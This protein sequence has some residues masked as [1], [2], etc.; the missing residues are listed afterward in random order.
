MTKKKENYKDGLLAEFYGQYE[1][2][3]PEYRFAVD[4]AFEYGLQRIDSPILDVG[5]RNPYSVRH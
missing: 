1:N 4:K 5:C 2:R 3:I